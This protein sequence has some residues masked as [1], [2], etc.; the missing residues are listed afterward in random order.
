MILSTLEVEMCVDGGPG[1]S[2]CCVS[3][4]DKVIH[5]LF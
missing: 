1:V 3:A 2:L 4:L 5:D